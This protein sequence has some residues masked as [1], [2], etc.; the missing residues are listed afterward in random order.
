M[1]AKV[2]YETKETLNIP[3]RTRIAPLLPI[4]RLA[5]Y[6]ELG[7]LM[8][9]LNKKFINNNNNGIYSI[10]IE[11]VEYGDYHKIY[12]YY[13]ELVIQRLNEISSEN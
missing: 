3:P 8:K 11:S 7:I 2:K 12:T 6:D 10:V 1:F 5:T 4:K 9:I 13:C